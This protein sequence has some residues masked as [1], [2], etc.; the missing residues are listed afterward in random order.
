MS[1]GKSQG[2]EAGNVWVG[3]NVLMKGLTDEPPG[4]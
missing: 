4:T 1:Q 3:K 2:D